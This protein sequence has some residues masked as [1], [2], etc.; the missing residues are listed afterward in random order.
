MRHSNSGRKLSRT[1]AHRKALLHNLAKALLIHGKIRTTEIKAKELRRVVEP[2]ITLA[3]RNDLHARRQAYRVLNDHALVKRLF[4]EIGPVF[5]G[6]PGGYTRILKMAMPRKG[7][8]AP[9][10]II[11]LTRSTEAAV[12][13]TKAAPAKEAKVAD[14]A[15]KPKRARKPKAE[16]AAAESAK[17]EGEAN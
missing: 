15:A 8:N 11:E 1:P 17:E 12:E 6:V 5:A 10:A 14:E 7:D 16:E 4:D 9:M 3:K 2:L 13:A